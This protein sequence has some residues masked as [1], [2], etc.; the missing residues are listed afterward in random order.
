GQA[1]RQT[2]TPLLAASLLVANLL[3]GIALLIL[4]GRRVAQRRAAASPIGGKG[5]LHVRLVALFS[6]ISAVPTLLVVIFASVLFQY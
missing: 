5:R 6:F 2:L 4:I 3:P 1:P